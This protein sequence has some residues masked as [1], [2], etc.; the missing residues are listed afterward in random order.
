MLGIV[1]S[2]VRAMLGIET[3]AFPI[4][5]R[6]GESQHA[7]RSSARHLS[8]SHCLRSIG[9]SERSCDG[10]F[11]VSKLLIEMSKLVIA[12]RYQMTPAVAHNK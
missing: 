4:G 2:V 12:N 3:H 11:K 7:R 10:G 8:I 6:K 9:K 5:R 1:L